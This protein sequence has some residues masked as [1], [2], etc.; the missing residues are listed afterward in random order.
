[1]TQRSL[2]AVSLLIGA[3]VGCTGNISGVTGASG[4]SHPNPGNGLGSGGSVGAGASTGVGAGVGVSSNPGGGAGTIDP[5]KPAD[6]NAAGPMPLRR[7][8]QREYNNTVRDLLGVTTSPATNFP[9][10]VDAT[11]IFR[12]FGDV[13]TLDASRMQEAAEAISPTVDTTKIAPCATGTA[14]TACVTNFLNTFGLHAYRR[15]LTADESTRLSALYQTGKTTL[16]LDYAGGIKLLV[17]TMLQAPGFVYRWE[18]GPV[19]PTLQGSVVQLTSYEVASRL[20]YFLWGTMPD[21]ALFDAAAA[22]KLATQSDVDTQARRMI[23]DPKAHDMMASFFQQWL[24]LD[25]VAAR[26]KDATVYPQFNDALKASMNSESLAFIDNVAF[27]GDG[28]LSTFLTANYSYVDTTLAPVYGVTGATATAAKLNLDATQ[29]A[30]L[31]TQSAFLTVTG[32]TDGSN[33][34]K[35][36][37]KVYERL[38]CG[39]LPP[40]P[41]NV[42]PA[43]PASAGGTTRQRFEVH[44]TMACAKACHTIMDPIGYAFENYDGIGQYRTT[45]NGMPV[46]ATGAITLDGVAKNF[47]NAVELT[48]MLATSND[49]RSCFVK[50]WARFAFLRLETDADTAS[51]NGAFTAFTK[52]NFTLHELLVSVATS[53]SFN[54]RSPSAGEIQ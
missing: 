35:R 30:G 53:R 19:S 11:F 21:Q 7:L 8:N 46:D 1:M 3:A 52:A 22:G 50:Q 4:T 14:E 6:P 26:P 33:P 2:F 37:R 29:R 49:V 54:Y 27:Q 12:R 18:L 40:P 42:P 5:S 34:V 41:P 44:D 16:M 20:S 17:E 39:V 36:G 31:L 9:T 51:L 45:D 28:A 25:Q 47:K 15:P 43:A 24:S 38:L 32:A 13:S 10:D 48:N 23:E